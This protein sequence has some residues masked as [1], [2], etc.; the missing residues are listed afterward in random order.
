MGRRLATDLEGGFVDLVDAHGSMVLSIG[1]RL[2]DPQAAEDV[3]QDTFLRAWR[4]FES[5]STDPTDVDLRPWLATIA[6]NLV[7]NER[8]R[9]GRKPV[10]ELSD[11]TARAIGSDGPGPEQ[12]A[13]ESIGGSP[14]VAALRS[15]PDVQREAVVF[16]HVVGLSTGETAEAMD[17]PQGTLKS[18]L[19][20]GL[21][22]LRTQLAHQQTEE[23]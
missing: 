16:R 1:A 11:D 6:L 15:L 19:S 14:L 7:R 10:G 9:R 3:L 4:A 23:P 12:E 20:R 21:A 5:G 2:G 22:D 8:R 17:C 18:H 13:M